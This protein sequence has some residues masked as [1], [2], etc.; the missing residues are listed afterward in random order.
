MSYKFKFT[1][2]RKKTEIV[3]NT[4]IEEENEEDCESEKRKASHDNGEV[5]FTNF[6]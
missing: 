4:L 2:E 1:N 6:Q 3:I 5:N